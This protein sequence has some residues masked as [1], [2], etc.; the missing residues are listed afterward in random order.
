MNPFRSITRI[1]IDVFGITHPTP[2]QER[3]ATW[4]IS[5]MLGLI[6]VAVVAAFFAGY[7]L[8]HQ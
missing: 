2:K 4:F 1:F 6:L 3:Q 7:R 5:I 8:S